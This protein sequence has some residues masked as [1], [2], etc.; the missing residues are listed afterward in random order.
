MITAGYWSTYWYGGHIYGTEIARGLDVFALEPSDYITANEIAAASLKDADLT[1]N[2]QTQ[3]RV[4]WPDVPVV[5]RA[6]MD[7]LQRSNVIDNGL[8]LQ[9][10]AALNQADGLLE[11]NS[12]NS[13]LADE[14]AE[15]AEEMENVG[16]DRSGRSRARYL[17]LASTLEG[18]AQQL[19]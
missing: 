4:S 12:S 16:V 8:V 10:N 17:S 1:V 19:R 3:E 11:S 13:G 2:A 7:Q 6:Y 14:F 9:L 5:A 18:I 15:L